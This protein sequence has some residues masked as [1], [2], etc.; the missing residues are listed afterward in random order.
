MRLITLAI[1][2]PDTE[3]PE[4]IGLAG[5]SRLL[6]ELWRLRNEGGADPALIRVPEIK[7]IAVGL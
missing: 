5:I 1:P 4:A 6:M 2:T 3:R 7:R